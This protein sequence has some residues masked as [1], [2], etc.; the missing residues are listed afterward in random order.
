MTTFE[1]IGQAAVGIAILYV[2]LWLLF[3]L[4]PGNKK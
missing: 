4:F 1:D 3:K 2:V